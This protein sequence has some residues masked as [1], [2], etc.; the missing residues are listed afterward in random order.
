MVFELVGLC[1]G[2]QDIGQD[3]Q[4]QSAG[5]GG[6]GD[7]TEGDGQAANAG[8]QNDGDHKQILALVQVY[9]LHH[10]QAGNSDEAVQCHANAAH[11]A[12]GDGSQEGDEGAEEGNDHTH[13]G[14]GGDGDYRGVPGNGYAANGFAVGGVGAAAEECAAHGANAVT[15]QGA[16]QTGLCQQILADDGRKVLMVGN[17]LSKDHECHRHIGNCQSGNIG[18][19]N[20]L[21]AFAKLQEGEVGNS[22]DLHIGKYGKVDDLQGCV[23]GHTANDGEDGGYHIAN[24]DAQNEGDQLHHLLAVNGEADDGEQGAKTAEQSHIGAAGGNKAHIFHD[25]AYLAL[26]QVTD[27]VAC[28]GKTDDGNGGSDD[29]R[30][31]ELIHPLNAYALDHKSDDHIDKACENSADDQTNMA[32]GNGS[33]AC[34]GS[35]HRAKEC[36]GR[37]QINGA[38]ELGE[39]LVNDGANTCAKEGGGLAHTVADDGGNGDG[40]GQNGQYLLECEDQKLDKFGSVVN[41]INEIHFLTSICFGFNRRRL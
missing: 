39:E 29:G 32:C 17:M 18:S 6:Q 36:E 21:E 5:D 23:I 25:D 3:A 30:G 7:L 26:G 2:D 40:G 15:Q 12:V 35:A 37:A 4:D 11:H 19:V 34:E 28:Q 41:A 20:C 9:L 38:A 31:H 8:D 24:Q 33:N 1:F 16:V 22:E 13:N 10:L 27:G 14:G